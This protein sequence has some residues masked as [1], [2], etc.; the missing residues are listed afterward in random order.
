MILKFIIRIAVIIGIA[1][2]AYFIVTGKDA[3]EIVTP[4]GGEEETP[5]LTDLFKE[6]GALRNF[7]DRIKGSAE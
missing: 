2:L 4:E 7:I 3:A 5:S 6:G 1:A